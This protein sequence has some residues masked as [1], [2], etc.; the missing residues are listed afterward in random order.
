MVEL[1][2]RLAVMI[3]FVLFAAFIAPGL[4]IMYG[5]IFYSENF[6]DPLHDLLIFLRWVSAFAC[7]P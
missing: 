1:G 2:K 6:K 7:Y 3:W 5:V 4:L